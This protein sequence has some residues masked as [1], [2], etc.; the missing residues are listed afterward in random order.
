MSKELFTRPLKR[1]YNIIKLN[2]KA[3]FNRSQIRELNIHRTR[4]QPPL[5]FN[6]LDA[7]GHLPDKA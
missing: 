7:N 3:E 2:Y 1:I 4:L 6:S 5:G